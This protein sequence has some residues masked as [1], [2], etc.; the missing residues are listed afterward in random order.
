LI[1]I[2]QADEISG[3]GVARRHGATSHES[4]SG[5]ILRQVLV[6][7]ERAAKSGA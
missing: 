1:L 4:P 3:K 5:K 2:E 7:K 6:E